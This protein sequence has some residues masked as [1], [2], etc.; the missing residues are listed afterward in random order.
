MNNN[1]L[2][3]F[4]VL[5]GK[6]E[7][8]VSQEPGKVKMYACGITASGDAHVGHAYQAIVFDVINK[9]LEYLGY[10]INYVD[11]KV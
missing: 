4:N 8:F 10:D 6:K 5:K 1:E 11:Y 7:K 9:Y 2:K 3:I